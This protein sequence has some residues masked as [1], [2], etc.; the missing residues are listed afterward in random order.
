M[1]TRLFSIILL[2]IF[3][4]Y[5]PKIIRWLHKFLFKASE[6]L[7]NKSDFYWIH[8]FFVHLNILN[9]LICVW[10]LRKTVIL[11]HISDFFFKNC[12]LKRWKNFD[13]IESKYCWNNEIFSK[14]FVDLRIGDNV[15]GKLDPHVGIPEQ[16]WKGKRKKFFFEIISMIFN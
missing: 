7:L 15:Y 1:L 8:N 13:L 16:T 10:Y 9:E 4:R 3:V 2:R 11:C 14:N 12:F 6:N 5:K